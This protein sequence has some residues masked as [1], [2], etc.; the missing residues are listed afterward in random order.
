MLA[1]KNVPLHSDKSAG[2][3]AVENSWKITTAKLQK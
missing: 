3:A 1:E 2:Q